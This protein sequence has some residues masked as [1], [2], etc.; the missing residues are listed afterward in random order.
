MESL[1]YRNMREL[2][3]GF[4]AGELTVREFHRE[5]IRLKNYE[6]AEDVEGGNTHCFYIF[7]AI[8]IV[9]TFFFL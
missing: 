9:A 7:G 2:R 4:K 8:G 5:R 3:Q 1:V 6:S